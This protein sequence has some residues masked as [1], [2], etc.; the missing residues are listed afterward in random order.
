MG[1][2]QV[3][4]ISGECEATDEQLKTIPR[5]QG[6]INLIFKRDVVETLQNS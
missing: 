5:D 2:T 4:R 6:T 3:H 1:A